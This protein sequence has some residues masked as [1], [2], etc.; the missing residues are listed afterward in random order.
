MKKALVK[1][2]AHVSGKR[3]ARVQA[4]KPKLI[5]QWHPTK[6]AP[7]TPKN[8]AAHSHKKVWWIC[9]KGHE[10]EAAPYTRLKS[11]CPYCAG[12]RVCKDNCLQTINPKLA[13]EWHPTKNLPLT[14]ADVTA[15]SGKKAWWVCKKG[16]TWQG[17]IRN[18]NKGVGCPFCAKKRASK[19]NCLQALNPQLAR[20]WN[21]SRNAPLS[22]KDV[23]PYSRK[24]VWWIC[25]K[26]HEWE[27]VIRSRHHSGSECPY[28]KGR[29]ANKE[30]SL[31]TVNKRLAREW[32]PTKNQPL[33]PRDVT[34][35]SGKK[36][37]WRCAKG[38]EWEA[39]VYSR[40]AGIGCPY[41]SG[42]FVCKDNC[43]Q[44]V[45]PMLAREWHPT[46]NAPLMSK[47]VTLH[48]NKNVW[49]ICR[50]G[51]EWKTLIH[52]RSAGI[53]CPYCGGR[54]ASEDSCLQTANPMLAREW[55]PTKNAPLTP[56]HV[57][58]RSQRP[59]WWICRK[60]HEWKAPI[61]RRNKG[62]GCP[63]CSGYRA[64]KNNSLETVSPTIAREWHP[65]KNTRWTPGDVAPHSQRQVWWKCK[66]GHEL[67]EP[68][69]SRYRRGGCPVCTLKK[70]APQLFEPT[71][72]S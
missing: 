2:T 65:K 44:T 57:P 48:S 46:K 25:D 31:E 40:S 50:R 43:L 38:H 63:Y 36:I 66:K 58:P 41:C 12:R 28:C 15:G 24:R 5:L 56:K 59:V 20:Q 23:T 17:N 14:P 34:A 8:T 72:R 4:V 19:E 51:H 11:G 13:R 32:H 39:V 3:Q 69:Y 18:R 62:I 21:P 55:H 26:G 22:P 16:H 67:R 68:V 42:H 7:L 9:G 29:R 27:T 54:R 1:S 6:N 70:K 53:G 45:N 33:T 71:Y 30:N 60:N 64:T 61:S 37:W 52:S 47:D 35:G 49:W 10:W